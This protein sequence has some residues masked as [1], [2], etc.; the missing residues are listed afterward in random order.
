MFSLVSH[1]GTSR[2]L[3]PFGK[4]GW[5]MI[6]PYMKTFVFV[7]TV[8]YF[9]ACSPV[10]FNKAALPSDCSNVGGQAACIQTCDAQNNC[11]AEYDTHQQVGKG[12]ADILFI[13]DNSGSMSPEQQ[14]MADSFPTFISSIANLDYRLAIT[15]TDISGVD[16]NNGTSPMPSSLRD[17]SLIDFGSGAGKYLTPTT[18]SADSLFKATIKRQET[19][20]CEANNYRASSCP[21]ADE[22]G[23][24]AAYLATAKNE[25]NFIRSSG[26]MA[27]IVL[28]DEDVRSNLYC[29]GTSKPCLSSY[30]LK[31]QDKADFLI[32]D[33]K[34]RFPGKTLSVHSIIV[35]DSSCQQAQTGQ[36]GNPDIAGSI[37]TQY[38][39]LSNKTGG[40]VGSICASSYQQQ[41]G[42]IGSVI[43]NQISS[44]AFACTPYQG[45]F[46]LYING[47]AA[48][49]NQ[50]TVD[51]QKLQINFTQALAA[52]TQI[53]LTYK[54]K[55]N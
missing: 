2:E 8:T 22:R 30:N 24:Y 40:V 32:A 45:Q 25:S 34:K 12:V 26:H 10:K 23:I 38:R 27:I 55:V 54:C 43:T 41:L 14:R 35:N 51:M 15:T 20:N 46:A 5:F 7:A 50:Y 29:D 6:R 17:G 3:T 1:C 42:Q 47:N 48:S 18:G 37:G 19:L 52:N 44:V 9:V 28:S 33:F 39:D 11:F 49:Q 31:T 21:S 13:D 36:L 16:S 53:E 4:E